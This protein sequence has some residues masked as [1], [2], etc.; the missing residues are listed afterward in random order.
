MVDPNINDDVQNQQ[1]SP[2]SVPV[3]SE[4]GIFAQETSAE[5]DSNAPEAPVFEVLRKQES[6][7]ASPVN[8]PTD[9]PVQV[10][11]VMNHVVDLR[12]KPTVPIPKPIRAI[13]PSADDSTKYAADTEQDFITSIK[14]SHGN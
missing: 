5:S 9:D 10:T 12:R 7:V 13:L 4:K 8:T 14:A 2:S 6:P 3:S 11:T 1:S